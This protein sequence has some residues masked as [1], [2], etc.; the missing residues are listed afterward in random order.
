[1]FAWSNIGR[2]KMYLKR[3]EIRGFKSFAD[4]TEINLN[5][6]VNIIVGPNGC[7]KSNIVDSIRWVLGET[8]IRNLRGLNSEDVIFN[9]TDN[10]KALSLALVNI[11]ID[12]ND[13]ILPVDYDE[14]VVGRKVYRSGE[15]EFYLNK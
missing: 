10:K 3:L 15:S 4:H 11:S 13:H 9:G 1:M 14:V 8:N 7:G 6:G 12:N 2:N 5:P